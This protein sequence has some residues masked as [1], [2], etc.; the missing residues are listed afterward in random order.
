MYQHKQKQRQTKKKA[1]Q[2]KKQTKNTQGNSKSTVIL[3]WA[4]FR[5]LVE[6]SQYLLMR[7]FFNLLLELVKL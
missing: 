6:G 1:K 7:F 2:R 3:D 4:M 5:A